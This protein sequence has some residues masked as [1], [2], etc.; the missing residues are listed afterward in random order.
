MSPLRLVAA[1][2]AAGAIA[3]GSGVAVAAVTGGSSHAPQPANVASM[4]AYAAAS[5]PHTGHHCPNMGS[6]SNARA[7]TAGV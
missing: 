5:S 1:M 6:N 2:S 3:A 7:P 4:T